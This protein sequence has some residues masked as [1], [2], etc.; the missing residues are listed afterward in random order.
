MK[1]ITAMALALLL[2]LALCACGGRGGNET[3]EKGADLKSYPARLREWTAQD[4][5]DYFTAEG[6]FTDEKLAFVQSHD[7]Y[8]DGLPIGEC[9]AYMGGEGQYTAAVFT[10]APEGAD[11]EA[12]LAAV[13][14]TRT[15]PEELGLP[16][17]TA[18]HLADGVIFWYGQ[19][20][21]EAFRSAMEEACQR[22]FAD[23]GVQP[24]F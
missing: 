11:A 13:R 21:D 4:F 20:E 5:L 22:L 7:T 19:S 17:V 9:A 10:A 18:D 3:E 8:F 15:L 14:S 1:R 16:G 12:L 6:V 2:A 24:D 23:L